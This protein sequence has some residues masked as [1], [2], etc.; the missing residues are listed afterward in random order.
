MPVKMPIELWSLLALIEGVVLLGIVGGLYYAGWN[1]QDVFI[2]NPDRITAWLIVCGGIVG[3]YLL[4]S[5]RPW[6]AR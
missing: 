2:E 1:L 3:L 6:R 4:W 5:T